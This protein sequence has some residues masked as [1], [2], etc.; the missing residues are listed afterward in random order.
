MLIFMQTA[1]DAATCLYY[2]GI[3]PFS[4]QEVYVARNL[5][6]R[7]LQRALLQFFKPDNYF[8]VRKALE[9]TGRDALIPGQPNPSSPNSLPTARNWSK[10]SVRKVFRTFGGAYPPAHAGFGA[11]H[12]TPP[13]V[14]RSRDESCR[15]DRLRLPRRK[16]AINRARLFFGRAGGCRW[17]PHSVRPTDPCRAQ[18]RPY[19]LGMLRL[20]AGVCDILAVMGITHDGN[21]SSG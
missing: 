10:R 5:R 12:W 20:V 17:A 15:T 7:K 16:G 11:V 4:K 6:D 18:W 14:A 21:L 3:D 9:Q 2:T 8:E 19:G 1:R 13:P